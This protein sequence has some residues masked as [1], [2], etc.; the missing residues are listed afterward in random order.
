LVLV[1]Q[2]VY[3]QGILTRSIVDLAKAMGMTGISKNQVSKLSEET[4]ERVRTFPD[5]PIEGDW[6]YLWFDATYIKSRKVGRIV[7]GAAIV[8]VGA[9]TRNRRG[10]LMICD[11]QEASRRP[12]PRCSRPLGQRCCVNFIG[13]AL[14]HAAKCQ[15]MMASATIPIAFVQ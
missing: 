4:D 1:I 13:N 7:P 12:Q 8:A 14:E 10:V 9:N 11:A 2:A 6:L 15:R 3:I 5:R